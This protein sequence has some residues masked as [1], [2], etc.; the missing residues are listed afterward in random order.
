VPQCRQSIPPAIGLGALLLNPP[1]SGPGSGYRR[2]VSD[3]GETLGAARPAAALQAAYYVV[4]G[5]WPLV[6]RRS[7]E[8]VSGPKADFWLA[9]T[10]GALTV[11]IGLSLGVAAARN[12]RTPEIE[13]LSLAAPTAFGGID[14][15]YAARRRISPVYLLDA[16]AQTALAALWLRRPAQPG[17]V[18]PTSQRMSPS[19]PSRSAT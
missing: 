8:R 17:S 5:A 1:F 19:S 10:V 4:T 7:F 3:D 13:V 9:R 12:R 11:A 2:A 18:S 6:D 16:A 14:L 15:V